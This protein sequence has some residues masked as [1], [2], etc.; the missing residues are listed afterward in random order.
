[1]NLI[2]AVTEYMY[3]RAPFVRVVDHPG[4]TWVCPPNGQCAVKYHRRSN[5]TKGA[6][7][8][9]SYVDLITNQEMVN[10]TV[11]I[12]ITGKSI[13]DIKTG[14]GY[15]VSPTGK[16]VYTRTLDDE[17][18][19][20]MDGKPMPSEFNTDAGGVSW[21]DDDTLIVASK[22]KFTKHRVDGS[23]IKE[24]DYPPG[25]PQQYTHRT[26]CAFL[27]A[28]DTNGL[29]W[30]LDVRYG[31][32]HRDKIDVSDWKNWKALDVSCQSPPSVAY[33]DTDGDLYVKTGSEGA[34]KIYM[35]NKV[36]VNDDWTVILRWS[37]DSR[38]ICAQWQNDS[39]K[40]SFTTIVVNV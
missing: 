39:T 40:R 37:P 36:P 8:M 4:F 26:S 31:T 17:A 25:G 18:E 11:H 3:E 29:M 27:R 32:L 20:F 13:D 21:Q 16:H 1:M 34:R 5:L 12:S 7:L 23:V 19:Q 38:Q 15:E 10:K 30:L 14:L 6:E 22:D 9:W 33:I 24:I 28:I 35:P 2:D